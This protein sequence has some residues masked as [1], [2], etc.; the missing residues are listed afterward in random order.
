MDPR[1]VD[2]GVALGVSV[3]VGVG[4]VT[5]GGSVRVAVPV[6]VEVGIGVR[7]SVGVTVGVGPVGV[8]GEIAAK[9]PARMASPMRGA[10]TPGKANTNSAS[11]GACPSSMVAQSNGRPTNLRSSR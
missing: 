11:S 7:V 9:R 6:L 8:G 5:P 2:V 1:G 10:F 3:N 4:G